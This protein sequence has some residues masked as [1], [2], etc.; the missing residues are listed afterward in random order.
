L[1]G[2]N[3]FPNTDNKPKNQH[4]KELFSKRRQANELYFETSATTREIADL[5]D[6]STDIVVKWTQSKD[7]D[8]EEDDRGWE[9]G[10]RRKWDQ[11]VVDR[12][13]KIRKS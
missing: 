1:P 12:I 4:K 5:L 9:K 13:K 8:F 6:V 11:Q 10:R 2:S 7:Q 3:N